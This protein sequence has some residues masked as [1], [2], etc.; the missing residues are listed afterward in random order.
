ML[1]FK[2]L[3]WGQV[4]ATRQA[5]DASIVLLSTLFQQV[6]KNSTFDGHSFSADVEPS[7][8][9]TPINQ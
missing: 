8:V 2:L 9:A 5:L 7:T 4:D 6:E 1:L 3:P